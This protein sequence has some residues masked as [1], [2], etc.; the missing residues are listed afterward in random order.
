MQ[1]Q[2][3]LNEFT[4]Y[5]SVEKAMNLGTV[6]NYQS[7]VKRLISF[8]EKL[9]NKTP[10]TVE[11]ITAT[12][13][14]AFKKDL[15]QI[16]KLSKKTVNCYL[17]GIRVFLKY[18]E[19]KHIKAMNPYDIEMYTR[20]ENKVIDLIGDD[21]LRTFLNT[22]LDDRSDL[23][24]NMLFGTGLRI[25]ELYGVNFEN[26]KESE[27][28]KRYLTIIGKGNKPRLVVMLPNAV[29]K[30]KEYVKMHEINGGPLFLNEDGERLSIRSMQRIIDHRR[31]M[32]LKNGSKL[33]PHTLRHHY[34]T[35]L[36]KSGTSLPVVQKLLGHSSILTT[37]KYLHLTDK[38]TFDA[39]EKVQDINSNF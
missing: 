6:H 33:T 31:D 20:I 27:G 23:L 4:N 16:E 36:L 9:L 17:V 10:L 25:F 34:A 18:L 30:M 3:A 32:L 37:Q 12:T 13:V 24:A 1:A 8:S 38:D 11:D 15:T 21:E 7:Y 39:M 2:D 35:H 14:E 29:L 22:K 26:V 5:M 19:K 28:G